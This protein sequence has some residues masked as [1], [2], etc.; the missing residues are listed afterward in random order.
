MPVAAAVSLLQHTPRLLVSKRT[1]LTS[2][3][4]RRQAT[5][6]PFTAQLKP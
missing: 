2:A 3:E 5:L 4:Q 6:K 1:H